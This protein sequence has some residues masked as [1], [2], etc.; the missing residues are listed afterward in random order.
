MDSDLKVWFVEVLKE[1]K[2]SY[3]RLAREANVSH[4]LI[5]RVLSGN[6]KPSAD[7][8]IKMA[9]ALHVSPEIVL[10]KAGILQTDDVDESANEAANLVKHMTPEKRRLALHILRFL[11]F[12]EGES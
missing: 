1:R 5:S 2:W 7:F 8:C 10:D 6:L 4:S 3:R 11:H 9:N 12:D